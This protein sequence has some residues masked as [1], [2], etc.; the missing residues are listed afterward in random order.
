MT[1]PGKVGLKGK[2]QIMRQAIEVVAAA[3]VML[4]LNVAPALAAGGTL[5][6]SGG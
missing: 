2:E 4:A 1:K 5:I 3:A 6:T